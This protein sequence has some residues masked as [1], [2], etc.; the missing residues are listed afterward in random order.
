MTSRSGP[1]IRCRRSGSEPAAVSSASAGRR[2]RHLT[3]PRPS[4]PP[5]GQELAQLYLVQ[6]LTLV[7]VARRYT[8]SASVV[9][10]WL[11][12]AGIRVQPRTSRADRRQLDPHLLRDRYEDQQWNAAQIAAEQATTVQLVLRAL[13][14]NGI[15]VRRGGYPSARQTQAYRLLDDL[16]ADLDVVALLKRHDIPVRPQHGPIAARFPQPAPL[17]TALLRQGYLGIGLSARHLELLTGQPAEQIL[18]ALHAA[19]IPVRTTDGTPSPW[20]AR[21]HQH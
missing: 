16:Y 7:Q 20:L 6:K 8:T 5:R 13:H 14:E 19:Q 11:A 9:R 17:T 21:H 12:D 15:P 3:P 1:G 18:D 4:S 10:G 2:R